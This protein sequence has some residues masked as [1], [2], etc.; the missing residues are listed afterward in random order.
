MIDFFNMYFLLE[1]KNTGD[2]Q[3]DLSLTV[4]DD[5]RWP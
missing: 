3:F 1:K 5:D 4:K 2:L